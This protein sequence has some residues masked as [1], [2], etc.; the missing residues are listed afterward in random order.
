M[1]TTF[2]KIG[3][4]PNAD[5]FAM[6][7]LGGPDAI[8]AE[9]VAIGRQLNGKWVTRE[10]AQTIRATVAKASAAVILALS[11]SVHAADFGR[12][13]SALYSSM[14]WLT[15]TDAAQTLEIAKQPERFAEANPIIGKHPSESKV[16]GF[17][18]ARLTLQ[19]IAAVS[20]P[21]YARPIVMGTLTAVYGGVVAHNYSLGIRTKDT[22]AHFMVGGL[23]GSVTAAL[24]GS[25]ATGCATGAGVGLVKELAD[26]RS[27][28]H[29][30]EFKDAALTAAGA[31]LGAY[32]SG[33]SIGPGWITYS[34]EI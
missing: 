6:I 21:A 20:M 18:A 33:L 8:E 15:L 12:I 4:L 17:M 24:A 14:Q 2:D 30:A 29:K 5:V 26:S 23:V 13:D 7:E 11:G 32:F 19:H 9:R 25:K 10:E 16:L 31:C 3:K 34:M 27:N 28:S 1:S 22:T